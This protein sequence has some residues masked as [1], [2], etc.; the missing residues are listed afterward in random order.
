M[1]GERRNSERRALC[2]SKVLLVAAAEVN[3]NFIRDGDGTPLIALLRWDS[4]VGRDLEVVH[5][6]RLRRASESLDLGVHLFD[7]LCFLNA[8]E[9]FSSL[10]VV[11]VKRETKEGCFGFQ[12]L[13]AVAGGI[14]D[15]RADFSLSSAE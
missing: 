14:T 1:L 13:L 10:F 3:G 8:L 2:L 5:G 11:G 12:F 4:T 7:L 15:N 9:Y 6:S